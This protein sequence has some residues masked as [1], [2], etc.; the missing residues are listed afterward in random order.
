MSGE[1]TWGAVNA[2]IV[3]A[4]FH[5]EPGH[6]D[7][8]KVEQLLAWASSL[9]EGANTYCSHYYNPGHLG[10]GR[11]WVASLYASARRWIPWGWYSNPCPSQA[12]TAWAL[13]VEAGFNSF[14][15]GGGAHQATV[16]ALGLAGGQD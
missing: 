9:I 6:S 13:R 8:A 7:P 16:K 15:L 5:R 12:A 11:E 14:E 10:N 1:W 2:A 3:L 4:D